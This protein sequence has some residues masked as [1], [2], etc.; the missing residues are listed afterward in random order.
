MMAL[1]KF[2]GMFLVSFFILPMFI[3]L[4]GFRKEVRTLP[5]VLD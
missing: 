2:L 5:L 4:L 3:F 1:P